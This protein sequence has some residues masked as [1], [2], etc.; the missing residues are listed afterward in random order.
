MTQSLENL[1]IQI[2]DLRYKIKSLKDSI[3]NLLSNAGIIDKSSFVLA[4]TPYNQTIVTGIFDGRESEVVKIIDEPPKLRHSGF[5]LDTFERIN[6]M[7]RFFLKTWLPILIF[8][9]ILIFMIS[10]IRKLFFVGVQ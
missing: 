3:N 6:L 1:N 9:G 4:I 8:V 7:R 2:A 10:S 5:D